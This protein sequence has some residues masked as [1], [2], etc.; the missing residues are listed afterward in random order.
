MASFRPTRTKI[1]MTPSRSLVC[2]RLELRC[3]NPLGVTGVGEIGLVGVAVAIATAIYHAT[4]RRV[5]DLP[6]TLDKLRGAA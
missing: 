6:I 3:V 2:E 4:G 1:G 5:R